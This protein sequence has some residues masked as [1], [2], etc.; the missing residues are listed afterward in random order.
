[1]RAAAGSEP[2]SPV[3]AGDE[4]AFTLPTA[5]GRLHLALEGVAPPAEPVAPR[6]TVRAPERRALRPAQTLVLPVRCSAACDVRAIVPGAPPESDATASRANAGVVRLRISP[7]LSKPLVP[8]NGKLR[9]TLRTSAPGS[10]N[11]QRQAVTVALR[12]LPAPRTPRI[13]DARARRDGDDVVVRWRTD[14]PVR[15]AYFVVA[16]QRG[17]GRESEVVTS[18]APKHLTG[19]SFSVRLENAARARYVRILLSPT[20]PGG[21]GREVRI[22][23]PLT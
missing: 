16:G 18:G 17:P 15:D 14:G 1:V 13:L 7:L 23:V 2:T 10:R 8:R 11:V 21:K 22:K 5:D 19:R 20:G 4:A 9:L 12:R 3:G 6:V